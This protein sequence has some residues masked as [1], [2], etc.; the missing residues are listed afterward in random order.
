M[1]LYP[2]ILTENLAEAA[3]QL[4]RVRMFPE[5]RTVQI[6]VI[7][8]QFVDNLTITP[9]DLP[10]LY[11]GDL[12]CDLHLMVEEPL[13]FV[14]E[15][16]T[17]KSEIPVRTIIGQ[18]ERMSSQFEFV[19][20]V[21]KQEW[22]VGLALDIYTPLEEIDPQV[23]LYLDCIQL[24]AIEAGFQS[25]PFIKSVLTKIDNLQHL[26][27]Q[28]ERTVELIVD[29]AVSLET[30]PELAKRGISSVAMGGALWHAE[31]LP[32]LV[33]KVHDETVNEEAVDDLRSITLE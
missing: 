13:D 17:H 3:A 25:Q 11:F 5:I 15:T 32:D 18:I 1:N 28:H 16:I 12:S 20:T 26:M 21:K 27:Q 31:N 14:F 2:A 30:L 7:D 9:S 4:E 8:G 24:M 22:Q 10:E 6:D 19:H 29:G 33:E 23:W